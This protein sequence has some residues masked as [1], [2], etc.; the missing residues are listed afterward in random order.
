MNKLRYVIVG[1]GWRAMFYARI[2]KALP[3]RFQVCALVCRTQEKAERI[4][5]EYGIPVS[6]SEEEGRDMKP[7]FAVIAVD[8]PSIAETARR[9]A[10]WGVPVLCETPAG[11]ALEDLERLW[12]LAEFEK[13]SI[14]VAE[15]YLFYPSVASRLEAV[16]SGIFGEPAFMD[17]SLAH[18]YHGASIIRAFLNV[19][20]EKVSISGRAFPARVAQTGTREGAVYEGEIRDYMRERLTF[21][22]ESKKTAFYDFC[23]VQYHSAIRTRRLNVQGPLGELDGFRARYLDGNMV[24]ACEAI[25]VKKGW[26]GTVESVALGARILYR[27]PFPGSG[28]TE[29]ETAVA[30]VLDGM[31]AYL[32]D[33][34]ELYPL[35]HA[36]QDAYLGILMENALKQPGKAV[37]SSP[38]PWQRQE[39]K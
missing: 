10:G 33:G 27:N 1:S 6:L 2:A 9:W 24:P 13:R 29:D 16:R 4:R 39:E 34:I 18:G 14:Q 30:T 11:L 22:F 19:W 8:K 21:E 12:E 28:L 20:D 5:S 38:Q 26:R 37:V 23:G 17:L 25:E 7:D 36:I 32:R 3:E 31:E 35:R 15:Q